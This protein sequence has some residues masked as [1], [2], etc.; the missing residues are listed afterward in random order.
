MPSELFRARYRHLEPMAAVLHLE[1]LNF[2]SL[3]R[4]EYLK[5]GSEGH[6]SIPIPSRFKK[7]VEIGLFGEELEWL[8]NDRKYLFGIERHCWIT[9][10]LQAFSILRSSASQHPSRTWP[11]TQTGVLLFS[12][13]HMRSFAFLS[14]VLRQL[15]KDN[16][17]VDEVFQE[18]KIIATKGGH[19]R[20]MVAKLYGFLVFNI[21]T[22]DVSTDT[23]ISKNSDG[24]LA[25][26]GLE[27]LIKKLKL[28]LTKASLHPQCNS[29]E[30]S[31]VSA[32]LYTR[33]SYLHQQKQQNF[34]SP[35][36]CLL[37]PFS[38]E[39]VIV[40]DYSQKVFALSTFRLYTGTRTWSLLKPQTFI[41]VRGSSTLAENQNAS[42]WTD[43][44]TGMRH[45]VLQSTFFIPE[46]TIRLIFTANNSTF[47]NPELM[48]TLNTAL[49]NF[50]PSRDKPRAVR[51]V[52]SKEELN[53]RTEK[54]TRRDGLQCLYTDHEFDWVLKDYEE[55]L[56]R[57]IE[58]VRDEVENGFLASRG[59]ALLG[60]TRGL[61]PCEER[62]EALKRPWSWDN[63]RGSTYWY[64]EGL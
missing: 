41:T 32:A 56:L 36:E 33:F 16:E 39:E 42:F 45:T 60:L 19:F 24:Y 21:Q 43:I 59:A 2:L 38:V 58:R 50:L 47:Q 48:A 10:K 53:E 57:S 54:V 6:T 63:K 26:I 22:P 44:Q 62:Q 20:Q 8:F 23:D 31:A 11:A 34:T 40:V 13:E 55:D 64:P 61:L 4:V 35:T 1:L 29:I 37:G 27:D 3:A 51:M 7:E 30:D 15:R 14:W 17:H 9:L 46:L 49:G 12:Y 52:L 28:A 25:Q 5:Q 18:K